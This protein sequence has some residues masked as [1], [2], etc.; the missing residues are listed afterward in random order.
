MIPNFLTLREKLKRNTQGC[1]SFVSGIPFVVGANMDVRISTRA[2]NQLWTLH[3]LSTFFFFCARVRTGVFT[4]WIHR[5]AK[6]FPHEQRSTF[7]VVSDYLQRRQLFETLGDRSQCLSELT[8]R[9]IPA[10]VREPTPSRFAACT[11]RFRPSVLVTD[12][13]SASIAQRDGRRQVAPSVSHAS[14][15]LG[16]RRQRN[17][18]INPC[19]RR[20]FS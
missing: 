6:M 11:R 20:F 10:F 3:Q 16:S 15:T 19:L 1:P 18:V 4:L 12:C 8:T 14:L 2:V 9:L 7:C 13:S 17:G 5:V